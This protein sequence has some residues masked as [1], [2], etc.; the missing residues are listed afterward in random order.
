MVGG[1]GGREAV[2]VVCSAGGWAT[3]FISRTL[4][5]QTGLGPTLPGRRPFEPVELRDAGR[6]IFLG[7]ER[8]SWESLTGLG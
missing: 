7:L 2:V 5:S 3:D 4:P 6:D 8:P 1:G